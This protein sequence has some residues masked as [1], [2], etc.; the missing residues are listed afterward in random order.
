ME[1]P[2]PKRCR[3]YTKVDTGTGA[4]PAE[5]GIGEGEPSPTRDHG[6]VNPPSIA[7]Y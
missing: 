3:D 1:T 5:P 4:I 6:I 2:A 7:M